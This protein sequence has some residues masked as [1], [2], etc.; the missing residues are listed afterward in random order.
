MT[1]R[2][3]WTLA[4]GCTTV[5]LGWLALVP[6]WRDAQD[7]TA[8]TTASP[9]TQPAAAGSSSGSVAAPAP[10]SKASSQ[11]AAASS[12][13][14][15]S[16]LQALASDNAGDR[17]E[18]VR[19]VRARHAIEL[20][21]DLLALDPARD[22]DLAPTLI[23]SAAELASQPEASRA[24]RT[25]AAS[26]LASWLSAESQ[27]QAADARGNQSRASR[28]SAIPRHG[29]RSNDFALASPNS[30]PPIAS[31]ESCARRHSRRPIA[32]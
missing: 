16:T 10:A 9:V 27:R 12:D 3:K 30:L 23:I 25:A 13:L 4:A 11:P 1:P 14:R 26:R 7:H 24:Q 15:T 20:L 29:P 18:A 19:A 6:S 8:S 17:I 32:H 31:A 2:M 28:R 22:P 5:A 21:P